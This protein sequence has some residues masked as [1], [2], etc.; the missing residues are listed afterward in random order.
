MKEKKYS[1]NEICSKFDISPALLRKYESIG[2]VGS[3]ADKR[4][5]K[6]R[7][8]SGHDM[9]RIDRV[10]FF[11]SC[12]LKLSEIGRLARL[13]RKIF[14]ISRSGL[15]DKSTNGSVSFQ[16]KFLLAQDGVKGWMDRKLLSRGEWESLVKSIRA[17][18]E[19][20][21]ALL[22][23]YE[24]ITDQLSTVLGQNEKTVSTVINGN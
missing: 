14:E 3:P 4:K 12:G 23:K 15:Q 20:I 21:T 18:Q 11:L 16:H 8:Y 7:F 1:L 24:G 2:I 17:Y 9:E 19:A 5:G 13:E 10:Q 22:K 6:K